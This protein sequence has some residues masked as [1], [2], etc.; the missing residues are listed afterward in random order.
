LI[1]RYSLPEL[2]KIWEPE[3]KFNIWLM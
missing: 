2:A 3:N 1:P